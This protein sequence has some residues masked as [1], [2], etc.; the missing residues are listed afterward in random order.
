MTRVLFLHPVA[1]D[2]RAAEW[3]GLDDVI[4]PTLPGHGERA[5]ARSGLTLDDMA[6]EIAGWTDAPVHVVGASLGGMVA[7]HL[8]L[9][10]PQRVASLALCFTTGRV[11]PEG[12]IQR[13][14][15]T[16]RVGAVGMVDGTMERWFSPEALAAPRQSSGVNY[17]RERLLATSAER[18]ADTWRAIAGHDVLDRLGDL[19]VPTTC[20]AGDHDLS[21]P[22]AAMESTAAAIPG[23][24]LVVLDAPH[25][26]FLERP[27]EFGVALKMHL[28]RAERRP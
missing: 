4:A 7:M 22:L 20:V 25:M 10:Y 13:A 23:A 16:E 14:E 18:V 26:G 24:E 19:R 11:D 2:S 5:R 12:M 9:N 3:L 1:L 17:A 15:L 21:T 28:D 27:Q 8:A 6:D